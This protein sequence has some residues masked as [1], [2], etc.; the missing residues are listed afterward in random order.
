MVADRFSIELADEKTI[1]DAFASI[2]ADWIDAVDRGETPSLEAFVARHP[3]HASRLREALQTWQA[4]ASLRDGQRES[5]PSKDAV[6]GTLPA[7]VS[8]FG[9]R[10]RIGDYQ[11]QGVIGSGGMSVVYK[12]TQLSLQREVAIKVLRGHAVAS[13]IDLER[14][15]FEAQT[16]ARLDH[17]NVVS[18][19]EVAGEGENVF[20]SMQWINGCNLMQYRSAVRDQ[21]RRVAE[22]L[23]KI[24]RAVHHAHQRGILHRDLKPSNILIDAEGEPHVTD[25]GLAKSID[26]DAELT[27]PGLLVGTPNYMA[28]EQTLP[29]SDASAFSVATDV[30]GLG[31]VLYTVLAGHPPFES[32]SILTTLARIRERDPVALRRINAAVPRD[33]ESICR[34]C[35]QKRPEDRYPSAE[36]LAED[37]ENFLEGRS[38]TARPSPPWVNVARWARRNRVTATLAVCA[39]ALSVALVVNSAAG[40]LR[41]EKALA[42]ANEHAVEQ[43]ERTAMLRQTLHLALAGMT[44]TLP[45]I[46]QTPLATQYG[47][48]QTEMLQSMLTVFEE[49]LEDDDEDAT[50]KLRAVHA[51]E[52]VAS[53]K[54]LLGDRGGAIQAQQRALALLDQLTAAESVQIARGGLLER[55]I[56]AFTDL[57]HLFLASGQ[58][59]QADAAIENGQALMAGDRESVSGLVAANSLLA[60]SLSAEYGGNLV[61]ARRKAMESL[62]LTRGLKGDLGVD[63]LQKLRLL[64]RVHQQLGE[65]LLGLH[66]LTTAKHHLQKSSGLWAQV[67]RQ[68]PF[69]ID[70]RPQLVENYLALARQTLFAESGDQSLAHS[71][72]W[73]RKAIDNCHEL[74]QDNPDVGVFRL[75]LA[76]CH[77]ELA[78]LHFYAGDRD[79]SQAS[80]DVAWEEFSRLRERHPRDY[81]FHVSWANMLATWAT[82]LRRDGDIVAANTVA[83]QCRLVA[84]DILQAET[85]ENRL[86]STSRPHLLLGRIAVEEGDFDLAL[87]H[88]TASE[89]RLRAMPRRPGGADASS[90]KRAEAALLSAATHRLADDPVNADS[91]LRFAE[92]LLDQ[93]DPGGGKDDDPLIDRRDYLTI[94]AGTERA[95]QAIG[96]DDVESIVEQ[97]NRLA[98]E[99]GWTEH[100]RA[101]D[102]L[103]HAAWMLSATS[104]I[105]KRELGEKLMR[106]ARSLRAR[107]LDQADDLNQRHQLAWLLV[108]HANPDYRDPQQSLTLA[109]LEEDRLSTQ[110]FLLLTRGMAFYRLGLLDDAIE[111]L[112]PIAEEPWRFEAITANRIS[113]SMAVLSMAYAQKEDVERAS[114][115]L[116]RAE[117]WIDRLAPSEVERIRFHREA[118]T[119]LDQ[120]IRRQKRALSR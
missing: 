58:V 44:E 113:H 30:H 59:P 114:R 60:A 21:P 6:E 102:L 40:R 109:T 61:E 42:R 34:R 91:A 56:S 31:S 92:R 75:L 48:G 94:L 69:E 98:A 117:Q 11:L 49:L 118:R 43:A 101:A 116:D 10:R 3:Q 12:A 106:R 52:R 2:L 66:D 22:I 76:R 27:Q 120:A 33:L 36:A 19:Y 115:W 45:R 1:D 13:K 72:E 63:P 99:R 119:Q 64:A 77:H 18:I 86:I 47:P 93:F 50:L 74:L 104:S 62:R 107:L 89:R 103:A 84:G 88:F 37:L 108:A 53:L 41:V 57:C 39:A 111:T 80:R 29:E 85:N 96:R 68:S 82:M 65:L 20:F 90:L 83:A 54:H 38:I 97:A 55:R 25:F 8:P 16:V 112:R 105:P 32:S 9:D 110:D 28:P 17:P 7:H 5:D 24:A 70:L 15:R 67:K 79:A 23:A 100:L 35:L 78:K 73:T 71:I 81:S 95:V 87:T 14:F 51:Y 4:F 26:L 46:S